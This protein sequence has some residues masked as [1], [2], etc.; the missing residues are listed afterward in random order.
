M[1]CFEI[2]VEEDKRGRTVSF[3]SV[4]IEKIEF[5]TF[6]ACVHPH[7]GVVMDSSVLISSQIPLRDGGTHRPGLVRK[8]LLRMTGGPQ[9]RSGVLGWQCAP[10]SVFLELCLSSGAPIS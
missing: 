2:P 4:L 10:L 7:C 5:S 6:L 8:H 1:S 3:Q 9:R